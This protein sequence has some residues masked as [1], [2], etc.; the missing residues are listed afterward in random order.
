MQ[1]AKPPF[2]DVCRQLRAYAPDVWEDFLN[3]MRLY[4]AEAME[5][6]VEASAEDIMT[7][8]GWAQACK[9]LTATFTNLD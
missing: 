4:T 8:K 2:R 3:E 1:V 9:A 6:V 7:R 5:G